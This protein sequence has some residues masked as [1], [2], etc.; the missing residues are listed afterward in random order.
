MANS[1]WLIPKRF[2]HDF[3]FYALDFCFLLLF[4][5]PHCEGWRKLFVCR[6]GLGC[7]AGCED[8]DHCNKD[9]DFF[10]GFR[11]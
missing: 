7:G 6:K 9:D 4:G 11:I 1:F 3:Q 5:W 10:H 2:P 8:R